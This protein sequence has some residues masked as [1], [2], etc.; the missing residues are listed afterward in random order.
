VQAVACVRI[1]IMLNEPL[2]CSISTCYTASRGLA[3]S[4]QAAEHRAK[5][6]AEPPARER[7]PVIGAAF[8]PSSDTAADPPAARRPGAFVPRAL[9]GDAPPAAAAPAAEERDNWSRREAPPAVG[10]DACPELLL[11]LVGGRALVHPA[12]RWSFCSAPCC[13]SVGG[14]PL[15][16]LPCCYTRVLVQC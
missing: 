4:Q 7:E 16:L 10:V 2:L 8:K 1:N 6:L 14:L 9:R 3:C 12:Q 13:M 5:L 11:R 15:Q